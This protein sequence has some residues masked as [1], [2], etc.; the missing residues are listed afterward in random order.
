MNNDHNKKF[1]LLEFHSGYGNFILNSPM[2]YSLKKINAQTAIWPLY[3]NT[4]SG[5]RCVNHEDQDMRAGC[6][7]VVMKDVRTLTPPAHERNSIFK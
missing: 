5:K 2:G 1:G 7:S 4:Y 6:S 3:Y